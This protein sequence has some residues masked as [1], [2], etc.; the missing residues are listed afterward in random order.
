M[1]KLIKCEKI[2]CFANV[3]HSACNCLSEKP[4]DPCP[5]FKTEEEVERGR[6]EA[7][8]TLLIKG[9]EDLIKKYEYNPQRKW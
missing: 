3:C 2:N 5:F 6:M 8:S 7:H 4:G 9:R 1:S